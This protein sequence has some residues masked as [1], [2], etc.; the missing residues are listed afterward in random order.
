MEIGMEKRVAARLLVYLA[1]GH[2]V[3]INDVRYTMLDRTAAGAASLNAID[4]SQMT[5]GQILELS[6]ELD[7]PEK[8]RVMNYKSK[9]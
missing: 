2:S 4:V 8:V 6:E 3:L 7:G 1:H 9:V 5:L